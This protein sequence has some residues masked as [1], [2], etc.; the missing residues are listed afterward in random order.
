MYAGP[1]VSPSGGDKNLKNKNL[2]RA[3]VNYD[4]FFADADE[5]SI[6]LIIAILV[7]FWL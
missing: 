5:F 2:V 6:K 4:Y 1:V 7:S 3:T